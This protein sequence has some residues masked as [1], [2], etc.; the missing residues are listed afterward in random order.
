M[1]LPSFYAVQGNDMM[2]LHAL[3]A[4]LWISVWSVDAMAHPGGHDSFEPISQAEAQQRAERAIA[5]LMSSNKLPGSWS[6]RQLK[7]IAKRD[8][9][10]GPVWVV[11]FVNPAETDFAR[12][13]VYVYVDGLGN[14]MGANFT[15]KTE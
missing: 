2:K 7:D 15:G 14:Y 10:Q 13:T 3:L 12:G 4:L 9:K 8:T 1:R 5:V 11:S 6:T